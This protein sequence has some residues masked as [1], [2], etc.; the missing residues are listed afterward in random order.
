MVT[1]NHWGR[2]LAIAFRLNYMI[3]YEVRPNPTMNVDPFGRTIDYLRVSVTDRCN[4]RCFYCMPSG[5]KGWSGAQDRMSA[6][7]MVR[8]VHAAAAMG[9]RKIRLTGGEPLVRKDL[10]E[11]AT[12]IWEIPGIETLGIS[13]NGTLLAPVAMALKQAGV[14]SVNVSLDAMDHDR[15]HRITG[16]QLDQ[17]LAGIHAAKAAGFE[18]V[19]LNVVLLRGLNDDALM[20]LVAFAAEHGFPIRFIELMPMAARFDFDGHFFPLESAVM[21]LGGWKQ[22]VPAIE[23]PGHGPAKY[24][25]HR[26]TGALVG[27]I[28]AMTAEHFCETCNKL[29]LTSDGKLRP[30]LGREGEVD[31]SHALRSGAPLDDIFRFALQNKPKDHTFRD[32]AQSARPMTAIGG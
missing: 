32:G 23:R 28:G 27:L 24:W 7:E 30:C 4:E 12:R 5:Y 8:V 21:R 15:Y 26:P 25:R 29:R 3:A 19:K 18:V 22:F 13:T 2:S 16:G 14:R 6:D 31:I 9:I 20:P 11:I 1:A 10:V 17:A